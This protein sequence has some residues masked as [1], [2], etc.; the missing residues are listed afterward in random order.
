MAEMTED[1]AIGALGVVV[2]G[3]QF[4]SAAL[5]SIF[6]IR[7]HALPEDREDITDGEKFATVATL[8]VGGVVAAMLDHPAPFVMALIVAAVMVAMYEW[9]WRGSEAAAA[10]AR[11]RPGSAELEEERE[12]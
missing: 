5:P 7:R 10:A 6:T 9:A 3:S 8:A 12:G 4:Y 1:Q 11:R 2:A